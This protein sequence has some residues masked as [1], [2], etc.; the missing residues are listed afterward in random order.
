[1]NLKSWVTTSLAALL[2]PAVVL[3]GSHQELQSSSSGLPP[4]FEDAD[5]DGLDDALELTIGTSPELAD[6]DADGYDDLLELTNELDPLIDEGSFLVPATSMWMKG[7][8]SGDIFVL[9]VALVHRGPVRNLNL[10]FADL[11]GTTTL[12]GPAARSF[13]RDV[14]LV[15]Q[16]GNGWRLDSARFVLPRAY[17][18][19]R[20]QSAIAVLGRTDGIA[21]GKQLLIDDT[22]NT[23]AEL[24][25]DTTIR[26][27]AN[28]GGSVGQNGTASGALFPVEPTDGAPANSISDEICVQVMAQRGTLPGS[29]VVMEV[30][31]A[32]CDPL[33]NAF[34]LSGCATSLGDTVVSLDL[35][36]LL[37][38]I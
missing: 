27:S 24:V 34:C 16:F 23:M 12:V 36:G 1:M 18:Q 25:P 8:A 31:D 22:W 3:V 28:Q 35:L 21:C 11:F 38:G 9:Q 10:V 6:T 26:A 37:G 32:Y 20:G 5:G 30:L 29:R 17:F 15:Q 14:K 4:A 13:L 2:L 19:A 33:P 7:Y